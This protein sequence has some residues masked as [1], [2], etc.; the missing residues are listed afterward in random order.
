MG[1]VAHSSGGGAMITTSPTPITRYQY[2]TV[3]KAE[4][5]I[6]ETLPVIMEAA[7]VSVQQLNDLPGSPFPGEQIREVTGS[8]LGVAILLPG[9]NNQKN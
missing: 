6:A 3:V 8:E 9:R 4:Q 2:P 5:A 1:Q 7:N